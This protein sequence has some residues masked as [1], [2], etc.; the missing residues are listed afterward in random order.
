M[1]IFLFYKQCF[2][3]IW[4]VDYLTTSFSQ[5]QSKRLVHVRENSVGWRLLR[6]T[7]S[8]IRRTWYLTNLTERVESDFLTVG[9]LWSYKLFDSFQLA[10]YYRKLKPRMKPHV[11]DFVIKIQQ[12][13]WRIKILSNIFNNI[14]LKR[15][16][17]VKLLTCRFISN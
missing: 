16:M 11:G 17:T 3:A 8:A 6:R 12:L 9:S 14:V 7:W 2:S 15:R 5:N 1:K 10:G 4:L 13:E